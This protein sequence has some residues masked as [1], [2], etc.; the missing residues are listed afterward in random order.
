MSKI[1]VQIA[2][3]CSGDAA[4]KMSGF[5]LDLLKASAPMKQPKTCPK[6]IPL[7]EGHCTDKAAEKMSEICVQ[8]A[9]G[10]CSGDEAEKMSGFCT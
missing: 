7:A 9:Q 2:G 1:C 10:Q 4:E 6:F 5:V 8:L 3:H